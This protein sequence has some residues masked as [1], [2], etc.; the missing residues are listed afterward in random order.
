MIKLI[1]GDCLNVLSVI[2]EKSIDLI[3]TDPPYGTTACKLDVIIPFEL[4]WCGLKPLRKDHAPIVLFGSEPFSSLLR[5]SNLKEYKYDWTWVKN[6][7]TNHLHA[8]RMPMRKT[9][10]I[11]V[12]FKK[13]SWYN[14]QKTKGHLPTNSAKGCSNGVIY[15][16][17][18]KRDYDGGDTTRMPLDLQQFDCVNNYKK[19]HPNQKPLDLCEYLIKTYTNEGDTVLDFAMGSGTTGVACKNLGRSFIGIEL[20]ENYFNI[21]KQRCLTK[22]LI[23]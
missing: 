14:P 8:K 18:N 1:H 23:S 19:I 5:I 11:S 16:G 12:F 13:A 2:S 9:E 17:I 20:D 15:H 6:Q 21:A 7:A 22:S 10:N 4:M 3:L